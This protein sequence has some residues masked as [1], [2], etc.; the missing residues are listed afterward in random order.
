MIFILIYI[1]KDKEKNLIEDCRKL[2]PRQGMGLVEN[3]LRD[4]AELI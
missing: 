2:I 3:E 1:S 4:V